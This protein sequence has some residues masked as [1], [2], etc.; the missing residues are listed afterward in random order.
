MAYASRAPLPM[1]WRAAWEGNLVFFLQVLDDGSRTS[2]AQWEKPCLQPLPHS[3]HF[4]EPRITVI[5]GLQ[6][7]EGWITLW[8]EKHAQVYFLDFTNDPECADPSWA[9]PSHAEGRALCPTF[10]FDEEDQVTVGFLIHLNGVS[11]PAC[12][13]AQW[14]KRMHR[15]ELTHRGHAQ[16]SADALLI[17]PPVMCP[18]CNGVARQPARG[19]LAPPELILQ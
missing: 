5:N 11:I 10:L 1:N 2:L 4:A 9:C 12:W 14:C 6:T 3:E 13:Q 17:A 15:V 19:S 18:Y 7:P 8:S 16:A